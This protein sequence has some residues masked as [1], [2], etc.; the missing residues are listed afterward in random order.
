MSRTDGSARDEFEA[1]IAAQGRHDLSRALRHYEKCIQMDE[2]KVITALAL[3][4][5]SIILAQNGLHDEAI[6]GLD[7][8]IEQLAELNAE[9]LAVVRFARVRGTALG[10]RG[11]FQDSTTAL[12]ELLKVIRDFRSRFAETPLLA[13]LLK[14]EAYTRSAH[15]GLLLH[16]EQ[17]EQA[18]ES[19]S[20]AI[21]MLEEHCASDPRGMTSA[22]INRSQAYRELG[23]SQEALLD[24][25]RAH[26]FA[27]AGADLRETSRTDALRAELLIRL[28]RPNEAIPV[29]EASIAHAEDVGDV[30][31]Q[32]ART[33]LLASA[34][35]KS[36]DSDAAAARMAR[37]IELAEALHAPKVRAEF[38]MTFA[39]IQNARGDAGEFESLKKSAAAWLETVELQSQPMLRAALAG[40]AFDVIR[41]L[42]VK[43]CERAEFEEAW[44]TFE[45]G[46]AA[47]LRAR[48]ALVASQSASAVAEAIPPAATGRALCNWVKARSEY[49]PTS[50]LALVFIPGQLH[51]L[52]V[53][54]S[55]KAFARST[56]V[57]VETF[58]ETIEVYDDAKPSSNDAF[59]PLVFEGA[60]ASLASL[61]HDLLSGNQAEHLVI[62][63]TFELWKVPWSAVLGSGRRK[64]SIALSAT[65]ICKASVTPRTWTDVAVR[66]IAVGH[67][68]TV[69]LTEETVALGNATRLEQVALDDAATKTMLT[70]FLEQPCI[71]HVSAHGEWFD[72]DLARS[73]LALADGRFGIEDVLAS[74]WKALLAILS[75]CDSGRMRVE[76]N[77]DPLGLV[78]LLVANGVECAIASLWPVGTEAA[79][80]FVVPLLTHLRNGASLIEAVD[81]A[82]REARSQSSDISDWG[83]FELFGVG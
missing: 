29:L 19:L 21:H 26:E 31:A 47:G 80:S 51:L 67:A 50:V 34:L 52:G 81:A 60:V 24:L 82:R 49:L 32:V 27:I 83:A 45:A 3:G 17:P 42:V 64:V 8:A 65:T 41:R 28:E 6:E 44:T 56:D 20:M 11:R 71:V 40:H 22:L 57:P 58:V 36:G 63:P 73:G 4:N 48:V 78:P 55:G 46:R 68:E 1:G 79:T 76:L 13:E 77:D 7:D 23:R 74:E 70:Q 15:G 2:D 38:Y 14:E 53:D 69:D 35:M 59:E 30:D 5:R 9:P 66:S 62:L 37:S 61:F 72:S 18:F 25:D 75:A 54:S 43:Y 39:N 10:S 12:A 16:V 33:W